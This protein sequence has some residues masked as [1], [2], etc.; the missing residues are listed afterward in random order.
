[1]YKTPSKYFAREFLKCLPKL[2]CS[3]L[4]F[5][6]CN[7]T[8]HTVCSLVLLLQNKIIKSQRFIYI[9]QN[10]G[11]QIQVGPIIQHV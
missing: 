9:F 6:L 5:I 4:A 7:A 3:F 2:S 1:M 11:A 8:R 10:L